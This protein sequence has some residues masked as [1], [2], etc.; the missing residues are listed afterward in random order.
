MDSLDPYIKRTQDAFD[1]PIVSQFFHKTDTTKAIQDFKGQRLAD[2][3]S[4]GF[5]TIVAV[6]EPQKRIAVKT[7]ENNRLSH[8]LS[9]SSRARF[10]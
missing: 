5:L 10:T 4:T 6:D 1:G 2:L 8:C 3:L 7:D 9:A